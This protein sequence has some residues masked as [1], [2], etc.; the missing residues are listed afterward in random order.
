MVPTHKYSKEI[1]SILQVKNLAKFES[2]CLKKN[3][4]LPNFLYRWYLSS[5]WRAS[6]YR[7]PKQIDTRVLIPGRESHQGS[8]LAKEKKAYFLESK[9]QQQVMTAGD[10]QE[11]SKG[12]QPN[13]LKML[14]TNLWTSVC[15][16]LSHLLCPFP[17]ISQAPQLCLFWMAGHSVQL[18]KSPPSPAGSP[19]NCLEVSFFLKVAWL[20]TGREG[21]CLWSCLPGL[22]NLRMLG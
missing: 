18:R 10:H 20:P 14:S 9:F 13:T 22:V 21:D 16:S 4:S 17:P 12:W 3:N 5:Q 11:L 7:W 2:N 19:G 6:L 1:L 8:K 15:P